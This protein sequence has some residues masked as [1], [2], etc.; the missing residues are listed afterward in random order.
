MLLAHLVVVLIMKT[1]MSPWTIYN[2]SMLPMKRV[3]TDHCRPMHRHGRSQKQKKS[4][5]VIK[6]LMTNH[7]RPRHSRIEE[8]KSTKKILYAIICLGVLIRNSESN[9]SS[10][11]YD[12]TC[13]DELG[14]VCCWVSGD[15]LVFTLSIY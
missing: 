7:C 14:L 5:P 1:S 15:P 2:Q 3:V 9:V 8:A 12:C 10:V 11:K 4:Y 13:T 6:V